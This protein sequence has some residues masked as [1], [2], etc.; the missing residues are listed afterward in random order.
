MCFWQTEGYLGLKISASAGPNAQ[1][2]KFLPSLRLVF[3]PEGMDPDGPCRINVRL[4]IIHENAFP[5]G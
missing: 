1:F 4:C 2:L 3:E 5:G